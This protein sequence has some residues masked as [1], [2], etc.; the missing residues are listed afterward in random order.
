M[1]YAEA[2]EEGR[3]GA[4]PLNMGG[5]TAERLHELDNSH[6]SSKLISPISPKRK[7]NLK[8][9]KR[10]RNKREENTSRQKAE[11]EEK[12]SEQ[13]EKEIAKRQFTY[14]KQCTRR[15]PTQKLNTH[16]T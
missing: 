15:T 12:G 5:F 9:D 3:P 2:V 13:R 4:I 11:T 16:N 8:Q 7:Q 1:N 6:C 14:F 10:G